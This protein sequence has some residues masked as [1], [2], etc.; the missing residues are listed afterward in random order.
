MRKTLTNRGLFLLVVG[1]VNLLIW[2]GDILRV[3]GVSLLIA[4]GVG[5]LIGLIVRR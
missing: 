3:Y 5:V 2:P 4:A 1:F